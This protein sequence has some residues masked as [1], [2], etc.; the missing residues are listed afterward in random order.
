MGTRSEEIPRTDV[1]VVGAGMAGLVASVQALELGARVVLLEK[2]DAPGGT[3][4]MSGGALWTPKTHE[5]L[6]R[7]VPQGDFELGRVLVEDY[8]DGVRWLQGLGAPIEH[9][10]VPPYRSAP[11][12]VY[13]MKPT[14]A[15][16][17]RF[18]VERFESMGGT[19]MVNAACAE[20]VTDDDGAMG[21]IVTRTP[22]GRR[23]LPAGAVILATG[24]FQGNPELM[25][26]Y[27]GPWSDRFILRANPHSTGDGLLMGTD[28]GAAVSRGMSSF[29]G[30]LLPAPP[31]AI[32]TDGFLHYKQD[33]SEQAILVNVRGER[34]T[35]ESEGD[36][37]S[38]IAVGRQPEAV[39]FMIF[40]DHVY[41]SYAV[42]ETEDGVRDRFYDSRALGAPAAVAPTIEALAEE[43]VALGVYGPGV[44]AT[45]SEYNQAA[46]SES[47]SRL[48]VP[49]RA[50]AIPIAKPP[51]YALGVSPGVTFTYGG[52][53]INA[54]AQAL[55]RSGRPI[56]GLYAAGA[57]AGGIHNERYGGGLSLGLVFGRR[58]A[59]HAME[60]RV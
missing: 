60:E 5:G 14:A 51:F 25:A 50:D 3:L 8:P 18:M 30:H 37:P 10:P 33:H 22:E 32:P 47:A 28:V 31:A 36:D 4:A 13:S 21:G 15:D 59:R 43:M 44:V 53:R 56:T 34:F 42:Q 52:L 55:D 12:W 46:Q 54:D 26:R 57:D 11:R 49:R 19:L 58:A 16:F 38:T 9:N 2:G 48:Q 17:A 1:V 40:D 7:L 39:A 23:T 6:R 20:L 45:V 29:Y 27:F 41:R 24:G 35:D